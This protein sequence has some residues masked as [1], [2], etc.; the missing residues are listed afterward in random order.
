MPPWFSLLT[1]GVQS[2]LMPGPMRN[3]FPFETPPRYSLS[4]LMLVPFWNQN[5]PYKGPPRPSPWPLMLQPFLYQNLHETD[6]NAS[7]IFFWRLDVETLPEP[8]RDRHRS[9]HLLPAFSWPTTLFCNLFPATIFKKP[10]PTSGAGFARF[11]RESCWD[12]AVSHACLTEPLADELASVWACLRFAGLVMT[13]VGLSAECSCS[14]VW[15]RSELSGSCVAWFGHRFRTLWAGIL[16]LFSCFASRQRFESFLRRCYETL[17]FSAFRRRRFLPT[18]IPNPTPLRSS[19]LPSST[20]RS[21]IACQ[22]YTT[23]RLS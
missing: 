20:K 13:V 21:H 17:A 11:G 9:Q 2:I 7:Q 6:R 19:F 1:F 8:S 10:L 5:L 14:S 23:V 3:R 18:T 12:F 15:Q 16:L 4:T 22:W